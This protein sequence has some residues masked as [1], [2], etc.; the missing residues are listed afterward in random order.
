[1]GL[2][3]VDFFLGE[4]EEEKGDGIEWEGIVIT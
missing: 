2:I 3:R 4:K 1:M